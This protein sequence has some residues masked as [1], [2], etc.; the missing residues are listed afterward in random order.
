MRSTHFDE[1]QHTDEPLRL[2]VSSAAS[3]IKDTQRKESVQ[4]KTRKPA[5]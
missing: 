1:T 3:P 5:K 2:N 4:A